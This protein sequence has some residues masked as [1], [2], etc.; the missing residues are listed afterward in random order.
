MMDNLVFEQGSRVEM[1]PIL[2][3]EITCEVVAMARRYGAILAVE[4][5]VEV[6]D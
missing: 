5:S 3:L 1:P 2:F 4:L 6:E